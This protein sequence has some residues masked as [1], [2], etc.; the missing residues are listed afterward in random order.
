M[1]PEPDPYAAAAV[2]L[3]LFAAIVLSGM[4]IYLV[5]TGPGSTF[6]LVVLL[7]HWGYLYW[8][9]NKYQQEIKAQEGK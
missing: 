9:W 5:A 2:G 1:A 3:F 4:L 8:A 7:A 6:W